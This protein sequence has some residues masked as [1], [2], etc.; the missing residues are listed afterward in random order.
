MSGDTESTDR[1]GDILRDAADDLQNDWPWYADAFRTMHECLR[2]MAEI[3]GEAGERAKAAI[4]AAE[5][6]AQGGPT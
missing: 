3:P 1:T 4:V 6:A 2:S 5:Q